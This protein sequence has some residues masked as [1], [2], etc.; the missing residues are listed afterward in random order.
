MKN[1]IKENSECLG[2]L[3]A[4]CCALALL[5]F[6][7]SWAMLLR[8]RSERRV[9]STVPGFHVFALRQ[10]QTQLHFITRNWESIY[11]AE[12]QCCSALCVVVCSHRDGTRGWFSWEMWR[13][14]LYGTAGTGWQLDGALFQ[15]Q[16]PYAQSRLSRRAE[17]TR[18]GAGGGRGGA[19]RHDWLPAGEVEALL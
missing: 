3:E 9:V 5:H 10:S 13:R 6:C 8:H 1:Q 2:A 7:A 19:V 16:A 15:H 14:W 12:C 11:P 18:G 17:G 4:L